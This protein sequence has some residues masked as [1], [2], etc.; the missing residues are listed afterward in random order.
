MRFA[1]GLRPLALL[2]LILV[3]LT[4]VGSVSS[5]AAMPTVATPIPLPASAAA[6]NP[7]N[8]APHTNAFFDQLRSTHPNASWPH[9]F[10]D[11]RLAWSA[12]GL[13]GG[14]T[15]GLVATDGTLSPARNTMGVSFWLRD[16]TSGQLYVPQL[17]HVSQSLDDGHLPLITTR[18][19][20][21][22]ATVSIIAF[23]ASTAENPI[24]PA[25]DGGQTMLV[26]T[27]IQAGGEPRPWTLYVAVRPYGP[28]GGVSP[29]DEVVTSAQ[30]V[31][32]NGSLALVAQAPAN[33]FGASNEATIDPSVL[34]E[35][36]ETPAAANARSDHGLAS[37]LLAYDVTLGRDATQ[38]YRFALP[39]Q[40]VAGAPDLVAQ[41]RR[42]DVAALR[43]RVAAAWRQRL[44]QVELSLPDAEVVNA[45]YAS[46]AYILMARQGSELYSGPLSERAF[47]FRDAAYITAA[48]DE[49]GYASTVQ[50]I[51]RLM[52]STQLPS[53]RYPPIVEANGQ[54][55]QPMKTEWDS[56]GEVIYSLVEY[57]R[58]THDLSFL[59]GAYPGIWRAAKFQQGQLQAAR[60]RSLL[61]TPFYGILPAGESAEDLY[62]ADWHHYWDD[63]WA[64]AGFQEAA[65]AAGLLGYSNDVSWLTGQ[66]DSLRRAVLNGVARVRTPDGHSYIPN[67]PEDSNTT[68]MARSATPSIWPVEVLDPTSEL[69]AYSFQTYYQ[70]TVKPYDGAYAHY[71]YHYWPYAGIS[72][73]HAFYRLAMVDQ[74]DSMLQ[75]VLRH[76]TAPNLYAWAEVV[77]PKTS[78]FA[79]GD[80]PHSWMGAEFVLLIRDML[81]REQGDRLAIGPFPAT[82]LP[83]GGTI[84][85]RGFPT[86][87]G[88]QT[89]TLTRSADGHT[90]HLTLDGAPPA[91]GYQVTLPGAL[92]VQSVA[93]NGRPAQAASGAVITLPAD[94]RQATLMVSVP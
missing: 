80:M 41:L 76:Q 18:W 79:L 25:P 83:A 31:R 26:D 33:R 23:A 30:T 8:D 4:P 37:G 81:V 35:R 38:T 55:R 87:L 67:G 11:Q 49:T 12:V 90:L 88:Q 73:A 2:A 93:V 20:A 44:H 21:G 77:D 69:V 27:T 3:V 56:Q 46:L 9:W 42:I 63:F 29:L 47:W 36:G 54:A 14:G 84:A 86:A 28:A 59:R 72:L 66:E 60:V 82:W 53:G 43:A 51:L 1:R 7:L 89:Y 70:H 61:G 64:M 22:Q 13:D 57:A 78:A 94:A 16:D 39:M 91:G 32:A 24:D 62:S 74:A 92:A 85:V 19:S 40:Q 45:F 71:N 50:P 52:T 48:L 15:E 58:Q 6:V 34:A 65:V 10:A 17:D 75:W 5:A 68:A